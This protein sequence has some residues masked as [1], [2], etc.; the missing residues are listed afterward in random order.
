MTDQY[1][2]TPNPS[3]NRPSAL[4]DMLDDLG[5]ADDD[6]LRDALLEIR[7]LAK[8]VP[9]ASPA[10]V[11]LLQGTTP[12][13]MPARRR[14]AIAA[15][16]GTLVFGG[17]SAAAAT[18]NLPEPLQAVV[19]KV[20]GAPRPH[21]DK[22]TSSRPKPVKPT[23]APDDAPGR[24]KGKSDRDHASGQKTDNSDVPGQVQKVTKPATSAP[25]PAKPAD[26]GSHGRARAD[27]AKADH[28]NGGNKTKIGK[29]KQ[30]PSKKQMGNSGGNGKGKSKGSDH[31]NGHGNH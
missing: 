29:K 8:D 15:V 27:D 21:A 5:Y 23:N 9:I 26:P 31:N 22:P 4:D 28:T 2:S 16:A 6:Q 1:E 12:L 18:N 3:T 7:G 25:G 17:A 13:R 20:T 11:A 30:S 14:V 10:V 19:A 24:L